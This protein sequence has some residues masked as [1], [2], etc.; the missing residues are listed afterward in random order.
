MDVMR[1]L[2]A[3]GADVNYV[4]HVNCERPYAS[5]TSEAYVA[6]SARLEIEALFVLNGEHSRRGILPPIID[7]RG[8]YVVYD[9]PSHLK[10]CARSGPSTA[11][12]IGHLPELA[13]AVCI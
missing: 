9:V 5:F 1:L 10:M 2:L 13:C 3:N 12:E 11:G 4:N 8:A 7:H 6:T